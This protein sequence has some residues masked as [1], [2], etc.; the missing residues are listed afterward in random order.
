MQTRAV[1]ALSL[2]ALLAGCADAPPWVQSASAEQ[3]VLRWYPSDANPLA[4]QAAAQ[5]KADAHCAQ[6]G[7][8]AALVSTQLSGSAQLATY[9]CQ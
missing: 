1:A 9:A 7:R 8:R 2:F 4:T 5:A 6:T 3:V